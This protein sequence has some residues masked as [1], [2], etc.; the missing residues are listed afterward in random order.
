ML[1]QAQLQGQMTL[2]NLQIMKE[3]KSINQ[4]DQNQMPVNNSENNN[5]NNFQFPFM[6]PMFGMN[7]NM[8]SNNPNNM[9]NLLFGFPF[10]NMNMMNSIQK[11][12]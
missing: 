2:L 11:P 7:N 9:N 6:F 1:L 3:L 4:K 8:A 12:K 10:M 5:G